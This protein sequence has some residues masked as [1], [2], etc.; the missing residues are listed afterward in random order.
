MTLGGGGSVY[1]MKSSGCNKEGR[2]VHA[3]CKDDAVDVGK[4]GGR[5]G[6]RKLT[7]RAP[8]KAP[9]RMCMLGSMW[10]VSGGGGCTPS[11]SL[12]TGVIT[13]SYKSRAAVVE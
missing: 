13:C 5:G 9:Q 3:E 4:G 10:G 11:C 2:P 12:V 6:K 8:T 7:L 1:L